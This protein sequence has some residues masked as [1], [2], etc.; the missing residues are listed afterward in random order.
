M[1]Q[2]TISGPRT[3]GN[4]KRPSRAGLYG[5]GMGGTYL[6]L[7]AL[8]VVVVVTAAGGI[9][10]GLVAFL[11]VGIAVA[12]ILRRDRHG[13][14][15]VD[16]AVT[17]AGW[18]RTTA[19]GA[20]VYRSGP[21]GFVPWGTAQLPG[22][23][24]QL[25]LSEH[26]DGYGRNFA[27]IYAPSTATY[28][29]VLATE[30][31]GAALV[32]PEQVDTWVADWGT[33]LAS[34]ADEPGLQGCSVTVETAPD[35]GHRLRAEVS[36]S[37]DPAAPEFARRMLHEVVDRYPA[38]SSVIKAYVSLT[39]ASASTGTGKKRTP[40]EMG[41]DLAARL[42]GLA[43][44]LGM[45]GAGVARA[46]DAAEMCEMV[47]E[48]Y[49]P[50]ATAL[51][52]EAHTAG[53]DM[54]LTWPEVGPMAANAEWDGYRHDDA[55]SVT[56]A[57]SQAPRGH[58]QS[59]VLARLLAPHRDVARKR[60][61]ILY[62]PIDSARAAALVESDA[63]AAEFVRT[64]KKRPDARANLA[65]ASALATAE[66]EA[67]GAGLVDFAM[68]VTATVTDLSRIPEAHAAID[69]L[70]ATARL[71]LRPVY[72]SQDSAFAAGLPLGLIIPKHLKVPTAVKER[73]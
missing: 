73:L 3:Y 30:P 63:T 20:N 5:L 4:W 49:N 29:V 22:L 55:Y 42:P 21:L 52:D 50:G 58:V 19:T 68:V 34:L 15:V 32:D 17:R 44:T 26:T 60:V 36:S 67:S 69:N 8:I 38:G 72:G 39:F 2:N 54:R 14:S 71:R 24:A 46:L 45:T 59:A 11:L 64:S 7:G 61:S 31:D 51:I 62:R 25:R 18:A 27:L 28:T 48:A 47:R 65:A 43:S 41:R 53:E 66:E 37:I 13:R 16:R 57:M 35:T 56:W 12:A 23:A 33:W 6:L 70:S 9:L 10:R 1:A 40:A